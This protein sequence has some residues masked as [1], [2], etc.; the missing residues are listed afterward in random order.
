MSKSGNATRT[1]GELLKEQG[2]R[3]SKSM[4][5]NFL[6]D[7]NIPE[8]IVRLSGIDSSSGVLEVGPGL[9][10]LTSA[11]CR[12]AG[13]VTAVEL[14]LRLLPMLRDSIADI[15]NVEIVQGNILKLDIAEL[16]KAKMPDMKYHVC[17]NLPYNITTPALTAFISTNVF[18]TITVMIQ[19]EVAG[20]ICASPGT[21]DYGAF[22]V[23]INYHAEPEILFDVPPECFM[24]RPK[25][26]SSVVTMK[27][28]LE[29][30]LIP[31]DE[32]VFFRVVRAAFGQRRKT[33]VNALYSAFGNK[34]QKA[35]IE[36]IVR[37]CGFDTRI[38]GETL[39]IEEFM[40]LSGYF[41]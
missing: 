20:R 10:A 6:V 2:F 23:F 24:P 37:N 5:Q 1:A 41:K 14:D 11:I 34:L 13:R 31:E 18:D 7:P 16:V 40:R 12:S 33:L 29:R 19:R 4:G 3:F 25:V 38:R 39:G 17:S 15:D 28:R 30:P 35:D 32:A 22:T 27:M 21:P 26:Y 9:G 8:K 36:G